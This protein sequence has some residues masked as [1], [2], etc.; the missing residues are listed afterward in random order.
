MEYHEVRN[1]FD[2]FRVLEN[3]N[4]NAPDLN[5]EFVF[6]KNNKMK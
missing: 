5:T 4:V 2:D 3:S 6:D 1:S